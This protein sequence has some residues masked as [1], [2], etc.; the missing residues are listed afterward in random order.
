MLITN[1]RTICFIYYSNVNNQ[2]V[3]H[4][5]AIKLMSKFFFINVCDFLQ[6]IT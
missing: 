6:K 4:L 5:C 3:L 1:D 2:V